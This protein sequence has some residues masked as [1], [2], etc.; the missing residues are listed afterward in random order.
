MPA[1]S[2]K[3]V[4]TG[5]GR[6]KF[7]LGLGVGQKTRRSASLP[8]S[9]GFAFLPAALVTLMPNRRARNRGEGKVIDIRNLGL[10]VPPVS[11][12]PIA[13]VPIRSPVVCVTVW[14]IIVPGRVVGR[15]VINR[16]GD[17]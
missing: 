9:V 10:V 8:A 14:T 6:A 17:W 4:A 13:V 12:S 16:N 15:P 7:H 3:N 5:F 11:A 2:N 1:K